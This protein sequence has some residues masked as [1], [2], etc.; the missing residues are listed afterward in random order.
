MSLYVGGNI[1]PQFIKFAFWKASLDVLQLILNTFEYK[2]TTYILQPKWTCLFTF[3]VPRTALWRGQQHDTWSTWRCNYHPGQGE[4]SCVQ[5]LYEG[6]SNMT[7]DQ[8][9]AATIILAREKGAVFSRSMKGPAT[10]HVINVALQ[11]SSWQGRW[12]L[13][14]VA[15]WRG[16]QHDTWSTWRCN[17]HPGQGGGSCV[18]SRSDHTRTTNYTEYNLSDAQNKWHWD[19]F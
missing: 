18:Q 1:R 17:C 19:L 12:E 13:C 2:S 7:R 6:A 8:R 10:W 14:S 4:G 3:Q 16:Q 9:G 11:L 5:S 15:L